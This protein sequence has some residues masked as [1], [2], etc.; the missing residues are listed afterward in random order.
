[1]EKKPVVKEELTNKGM[2]GQDKP[3]FRPTGAGDRG[4]V[5]KYKDPKGTAK[6]AGPKQ[7]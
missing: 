7:G 3:N 6:P 1:M 4:N 5:G 2:Q